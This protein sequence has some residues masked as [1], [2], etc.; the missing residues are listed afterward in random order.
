VW[1]KRAIGSASCGAPA[2]TTM[3]TDNGSIGLQQQYDAMRCD[4]MQDEGSYLPTLLH[5]CIS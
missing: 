5:Q 3:F 1:A 2:M 4:A